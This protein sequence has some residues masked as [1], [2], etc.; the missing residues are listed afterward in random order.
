MTKK[1]RQA[2]AGYRPSALVYGDVDL[3]LLDG[4]AIW[5]QSVTK[6]LV[7]G[8]CTVTL[9]LKA[10]VRTDGTI[11][12]LRDIEAVTIR[13]PHTENLLPASASAGSPTALSVPQA[14]AV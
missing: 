4:S 2:L 6:A 8:G 11:A 5:L 7:A 9:G 13:S 1:E 3:N 14:V 12:P 10:P